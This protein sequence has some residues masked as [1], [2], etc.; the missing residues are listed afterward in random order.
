MSC[1]DRRHWQ[2]NESHDVEIVTSGR[3][4]GSSMVITYICPP[5]HDEFARLTWSNLTTQYTLGSK[6]APLLHMCGGPRSF[7]TSSFAFSGGRSFWLRKM[8]VVPTAAGGSHL[9]RLTPWD[10]R[11]P[12]LE[13]L[14]TK[15]SKTISDTS[16]PYTSPG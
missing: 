2:V 6:K 9:S 12:G 4:S 7:T 1:T 8:R 14:T 5:L 11:S 13:G 15:I 3:L 10:T 16:P